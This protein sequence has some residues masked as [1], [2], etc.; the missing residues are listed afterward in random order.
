M[1]IYKIT[2]IITNKCYIGQTIDYKKRFAE[3][4]RT[5]R[6]LACNTK[7]CK[8]LRSEG[9]ENFSFDVLFECNYYDATL[10]ERF[11]I[12][13]LKCFT[14]FVVSATLSGFLYSSATLFGVI[15]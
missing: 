15:S 2:N 3:H 7:F 4:K 11:L 6:D 8:A 9:I 5:T 10:M 1:Y 13:S 12:S 14:R